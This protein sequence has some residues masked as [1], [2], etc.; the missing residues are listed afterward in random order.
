[1][2]GLPT[3]TLVLFCAWTIGCESTAR[4][5]E[6]RPADFGLHAVVF[7]AHDETDRTGSTPGTAGIS[8][9][10]DPALRPAS[11]IVEPD[12][13]L[14][15]HFGTG[16]GR[17]GLPPIA[18]QLSRAQLDEIYSLAMASGL[19]DSEAGAIDSIGAFTPER[20]G[21]S[22]AAIEAAAAGR[23]TSVAVPAADSTSEAYALLRRLAE[24][25]WQ[26]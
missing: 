7:A 17:A 2:L 25:T 5:P 23:I 15:A 21:G 9:A 13:R 24:L 6:D 3:L 16:A 14:R 8:R 4:L 18:R 1:M 10:M 22:V 20:P 11:Y 12:G 19:L 26:R